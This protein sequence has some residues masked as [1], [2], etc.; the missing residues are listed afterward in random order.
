VRGIPIGKAVILLGSL[1]LLGNAVR[2]QAAEKGSCDEMGSP[3]PR[4]AEAVRE[5]ASAPRVL[6]VGSGSRPVPGATNLDVEQFFDASGRP[7]V[8]VRADATHMPEIKDGSYDQVI[9]TRLPSLIAGMH[10]PELAAEVYRVLAP[11]GTV[12]ISCATPAFRAEHWLAAGFH[13]VA[14]PGGGLVIQAVK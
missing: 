2:A 10:G 9:G 7:L 13:D 5:A 3:L 14:A 4:L 6:N 1:L 8:D 11:G 12:R